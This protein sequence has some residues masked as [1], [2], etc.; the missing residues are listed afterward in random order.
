M[1]KEK[2]LIIS[3]HYCVPKNT[4]LNINNKNTDFAIDV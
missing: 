3:E 1:F 4:V 2:N